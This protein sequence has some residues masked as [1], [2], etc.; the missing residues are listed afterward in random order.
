MKLY[1][2]TKKLC[3]R[4]KIVIFILL[5]GENEQAMLATIGV[6]YNGRQGA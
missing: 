1:R 6:W 2:E 4:F 5:G 3:Q